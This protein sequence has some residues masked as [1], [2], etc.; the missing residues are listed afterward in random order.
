MTMTTV[1]DPVVAWGD[2][3]DRAPGDPADA[4]K[5]VRDAGD[6]LADEVE[7]LRGRIAEAEEDLRRWRRASGL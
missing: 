4:A 1:T 3:R 7:R 2:L 5:A 6:R